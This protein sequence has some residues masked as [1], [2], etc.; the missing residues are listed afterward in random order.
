MISNCANSQS[1]YRLVD[2][3]YRGPYGKTCLETYNMLDSSGYTNVSRSR[4]LFNPSK[5][6]FEHDKSPACYRWALDSS[7]RVFCFNSV[8]QLVKWFPVKALKRI[9]TIG[10]VKIIQFEMPEGDYIIDTKQC[11][12]NLETY[13]NVKKYDFSFENIYE[14]QKSLKS[15]AYPPILLNSFTCDKNDEFILI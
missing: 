1:F 5:I 8:S 13:L 10:E 4:P 11:I 14:Y 6:K 2:P 7:K 3:E 15:S 12:V 9:E